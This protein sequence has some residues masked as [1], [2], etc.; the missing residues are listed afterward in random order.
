[1]ASVR[2]YSG[3]LI[4]LGLL[5]AGCGDGQD[6][7]NGQTPVPPSDMHVE[8]Q[9]PVIGPA[10][11]TEELPDWQTA[12]LAPAM[13]A[14]QRSCDVWR[15]RPPD[16]PVSDM[17]AYGGTVAE[18]LPACEALPDYVASGRF[19]AFFEDNFEAREVLPSGDINRFTGYYEPE[20]IATRTPMEGF[21]A[22]IPARPSD[23]IEVK[24]QDFE[25][26][27]PGRTIWGK[28]ENGALKPYDPRAEI[29]PAAL[30]ALGYAHPAD[31]FFLQIQGSGRLRFADGEV[32]R[33]AFDSHNH[34]PFASMA[35]WL[36]ERGEIKRSQAGMTGIRAWMDR[37]GPVASAEAMAANP[38]FV[39]F[40]A[41]TIEDPSLGPN[42]AMGVPL[43]AFGS[44][45][46]DRNLH[47]LGIPV[48]IETVLPR[49]AGDW[50]GT[51]WSG[52]MIAQDTGGAIQGAVRGDLYFG[53]GA[54]A[55]ARAGSMNH[56]GRM[57][58]LLPKLADTAAGPA[59]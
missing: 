21:E 8:T 4:G 28:V 19:N 16:S 20:I 38:R 23:L 9:G 12:D 15:Q 11:A 54:E 40:R 6:A 27:L 17:A 32:I 5:I 47:P 53:T 14:F 46:V 57:W 30:P 35:N 51:P 22:P 31:V 49:R 41:Q 24:L 10:L 1:M 44:V 42:G 45:A 55:G 7:G 37:A 59:S 3:L 52:V 39:F 56:E 58:V 2:R 18:W 36:L 34:R 43:T 50:R 29:D 26:A 13:A 33:A 25:T 48:F